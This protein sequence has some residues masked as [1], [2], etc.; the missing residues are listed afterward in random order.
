MHPIGRELAWDYYRI[1]YD[2]ILELYGE[3]DPRIGLMLIDITKTFEN[4]FLFYELLE[5]ITFTDGGN[6]AKNA[7]DRAVEY[8]STN[9][10]WLFDKENEILA[11]FNLFG[12]KSH[13]SKN[14]NPLLEAAKT[15][16]KIDT[17]KIN[18]KEAAKKYLMA[19][20]RL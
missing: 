18:A 13:V 2:S 1:N 3:K 7:R 17:F 11:A 19:T 8:V 14:V 4:E 10:L 15:K 9:V 12:Q 5:H 6:A 20:G 16:S